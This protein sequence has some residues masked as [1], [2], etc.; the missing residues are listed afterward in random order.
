MDR[1]QRKAWIVFRHAAHS[2]LRAGYVAEPAGSRIIQLLVLPALGGSV[3]CIEART[4]RRQTSGYLLAT[5]RWEY[6]QDTDRI[7]AWQ[8]ASPPIDR[9]QPTIT[10]RTQVRQDE[11][12]ER[13]LNQ[14]RS[15]QIPAWVDDRHA[16]LDGTSYELALGEGF[17]YVR[18]HWWAELPESWQ[19]LAP[20]VN[21]ILD[22]SE[23]AFGPL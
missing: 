21:A 3:C 5:L 18:Y 10:S 6:E 22:L 2:A 14:L 16:G 7:R 17:C 12:V 4:L 15:A 8:T 11:I 9:P 13:L 23:K 19:P 1:E 20:T